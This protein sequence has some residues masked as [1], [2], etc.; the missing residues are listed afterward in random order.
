[1]SSIPVRSLLRSVQ[2]LQEIVPRFFPV[3][4]TQLAYLLDCGINFGRLL[5]ALAIVV[6]I[7]VA[8]VLVLVAQVL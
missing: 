6:E 1:M 8:E 4:F 7:P 2:A 3:R 5:V